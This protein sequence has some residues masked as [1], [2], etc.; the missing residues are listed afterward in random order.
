MYKVLRIAFCILAVACAAVTILIF[1]YFG[2]W[3]VLPLAGALIFAGLMFI[4]KNAQERQ[5]LKKNPPAPETGDFIT[6]KMPA[7]SAKN[8]KSDKQ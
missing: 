1:V 6:G 3:G 5:E 8:G 2:I 4:C 7:D